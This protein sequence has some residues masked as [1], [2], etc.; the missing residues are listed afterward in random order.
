MNRPNTK[1][2]LITSHQTGLFRPVTIARALRKSGYNIKI[3]NWD[4]SGNRPK[5]EY[6]DGRE[7]Y[8]FRF[9]P[10]HKGKLCLSVCYLIW[11]SYIILFL[12]RD[13]ADVY[14]PDYLYNLIPVIPV[15]I[16]KRKKK[17]IYDLIDFAADSFN[18]PGLIRNFLAWLEI[19][20][21]KFTDGVIVVDV[22]KQQ[23]NM[24][25]VKRL[26]V[27]T[28]CPADVIKELRVQKDQNM[29]TIY[30]G[31][32]IY[33]VRGIGHVCEAIKDLEGVK[34]VIAGAGPDEDELKA[35]YGKQPNVEFVGLLSQV[36]SLEWTYKA[37]LIP[38]FYDPKIRIHRR[39]SPA[40]L[41]DAMMCGTPVLVNSEALPVAET[42]KEE[43][44]GLI[45]PYE[46]VQGI[47]NEIMKL[48]ENPDMKMKMGQNARKAFEREYNWTA[49]EF[50]LLK[51]YNEV[52]FS[53]TGTSQ[54]SNR[55]QNDR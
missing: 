4:R 44:C 25:N 24:S 1:V 22:R 53:I 21:L 23:L 13:D 29:F 36:Q 28:N 38:V 30:Y 55:L 33:K 46:D 37:N 16:I 43:G 15:K 50:R 9:K 40:K 32:A 6:I 10:P 3:L 41:Y 8:N 20:C 27:V 54:T 2:T 35:T 42:V 17:I 7:I 12:L 5:I 31:G 48:K 51:L 52:V 19:F 49:M 14:H 34:F 39:A 26:A 45:V 18:W 11:W 47:K